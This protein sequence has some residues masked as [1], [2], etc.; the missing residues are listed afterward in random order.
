MKMFRGKTGLSM[1]LAVTVEVFN[2]NFCKCLVVGGSP[3]LDW[4]KYRVNTVL[5]PRL[6]YRQRLM[7]EMQIPIPEQTWSR[8]K[9]KFGN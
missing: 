7:R 5:P 1:Q 9:A 2:L 4:A 3:T 6:L 8:P